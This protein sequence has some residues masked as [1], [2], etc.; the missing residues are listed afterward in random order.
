VNLSSKRRW[1]IAGAVLAAAT[2]V[3][4]PA[5]A[6]LVGDGAFDGTPRVMLAGG[7]DT[8]YDAAVKIDKLYNGAPG[9][10]NT[11]NGAAL[12]NLG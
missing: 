8:T 7:S 3:A 6:E 4:T 11:V 12:T 10:Y 5:V 9:C 1:K 2:L